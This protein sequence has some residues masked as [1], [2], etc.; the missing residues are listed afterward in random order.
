MLTSGKRPV[1]DL[2][3][4][5]AQISISSVFGSLRQVAKPKE[6]LGIKGKSPRPTGHGRPAKGATSLGR[7]ASPT[8]LF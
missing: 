7:P 2:H 1:R 8:A 6:N 5:G 3:Y 4:M